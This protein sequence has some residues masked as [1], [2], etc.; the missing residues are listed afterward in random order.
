[1][2]ELTSR[3]RIPKALCSICSTTQ[4]GWITIVLYSQF[5][6]P[7][8]FYI[9]KLL[10]YHHWNQIRL[11]YKLKIHNSPYESF[12]DS[13]DQHEHETS[14]QDLEFSQGFSSHLGV[15]IDKLLLSYSFIRM[16]IPSVSYFNGV[17]S[18]KDLQYNIL[19]VFCACSAIKS[20]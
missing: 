8:I 18:Q 14:N 6:I 9:W 20:F 16:E 12:R 2:K 17:A 3:T 15:A 4:C 13:W 7:L 5:K 10:L 1:M 11:I 19:F